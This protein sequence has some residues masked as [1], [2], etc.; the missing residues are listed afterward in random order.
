MTEKRIKAFSEILR[1]H[2]GQYLMELSKAVE[3]ALMALVDGRLSTLTPFPI[4]TLDSQVLERVPKG[5]V[6]EFVSQRK[7]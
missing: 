4:E 6:V 2:Q 3:P 5:C 1:M 7:N